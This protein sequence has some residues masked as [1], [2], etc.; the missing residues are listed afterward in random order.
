[1][2]RFFVTMMFAACFHLLIPTPAHAFWRWIDE[3]SGP[4]PFNG[5]GITWRLVCV[6]DKDGGLLWDDPSGT[7]V[8]ERKKAIG[9]LVGSGC[10]QP[11]KVRTPR[12]SLNVEAA[13][14][15]S[16]S[17]HLQYASGGDHSVQLLLVEPT[18]SI[19][20]DPDLK[21]DFLEL[22]FGAGVMVTSGNGFQSFKRVIIEPVRWDVR[23]FA[24][25]GK[26]GS[27]IGIR[28]ALLMVP[29]GFDAT[30][31]GAI[32]GSFHVSRDIVPTLGI[33]VDVLKLLNK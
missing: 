15:T 20:L 13:W 6:P 23:P 10:V 31:F 26:A 25:A 33:S 16:H 24:F 12:A 27:A 7:T 9:A 28:A 3:W 17:N 1:M 29:R 5:V 18:V 30:D 2:R 22:G 14:F 4:G 21:R 8:S 32:P 11:L 19:H